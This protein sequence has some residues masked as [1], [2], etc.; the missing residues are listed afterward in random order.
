MIC[1]ILLTVI[2]LTPCGSNTVHIY[3]KTIYRK[4]HWNR[5]PR[6]KHT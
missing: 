2:G 4:T 6:T 3:T 1:Y 5:K